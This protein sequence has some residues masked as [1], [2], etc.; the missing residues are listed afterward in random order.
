MKL[1]SSFSI[2]NRARGPGIAT[3][4]LIEI[5]LIAY[6][7]LAPVRENKTVPNH[8]VEELIVEGKVGF[9]PHI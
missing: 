8:I 7:R 3:H 6:Y 5:K 2:Y 1:N 9:L 4:C